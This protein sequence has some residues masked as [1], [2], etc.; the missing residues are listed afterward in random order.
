M[1]A[2]RACRKPPGAMAF[3]VTPFLAHSTASERVSE[4]TAALLAAYAAT[5]LSATKLLRDA[6]LTMRPWPRSNMCLPKTWHARRVSGEVRV[7]DIGPLFFRHGGRGYALDF[8][9]AVNK[10]VH[11]AEAPEG[12]S[13]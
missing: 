7:H 9:G 10:D 3:T 12:G 2:F 5:S 6:M 11:F 8:S 13:E 1:S 4:T